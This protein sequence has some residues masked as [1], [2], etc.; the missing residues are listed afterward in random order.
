[1]T[2]DELL[3]RLEETPP[4]EWTPEE[5]ELLRAR[6]LANP[7]VRTALAEQILLEQVLT[8]GLTQ[9]RVTAEQV[10]AR[11]DE[12][13]RA[14]RFLGSWLRGA[15]VL[16]LVAGIGGIWYLRSLKPVD[17]R[18]VVERPPEPTVELPPTVK[19]KPRPTTPVAAATPQPS[20]TVRPPEPTPPPTTAAAADV[21]EPWT[22]MLA[23]AARSFDDFCFTDR[24]LTRDAAGLQRWWTTIN[25]QQR[26][27]GSDDRY[28][29]HLGGTFQLRSPW[30][31]DAA[32]TFW[33]I[34]QQ[35]EVVKIHIW[36]GLHGVTLERRHRP[37]EQWTAFVV[38]K[39]PNE[40]LPATW[41]Y[42]TA[43]NDRA[44]RTGE[45]PFDLRYHNGRIYLSRGD[46]LLLAV[47]LPNPPDGANLEGAVVL[48]AFGLTRVADVP[49]RWNEEED[50][51]PSF[52]E[53]PQPITWP[54]L[55]RAKWTKELP[56]G[57]NF[58]QLGDEGALLTALDTTKPTYATI[59]LPKDGLYDLVYE[60]ESADDQTGIFLGTAEA[61][62]RF[63]VGFYENKPGENLV[64][65]VG[66]PTEL[67]P[68][69]RYNPQAG[70]LTSIAFPA[71]LR[72][73]CGAGLV[74]VYASAD[75]RSWGRILDPFRATDDNPATIGVYCNPGK[76][77]RQIKLTRVR[78]SNYLKADDDLVAQTPVVRDQ[79]DYTSWLVNVL[80]RD[81]DGLHR[82][83]AALLTKGTRYDVAKTLL[84][85]LN[86][87]PSVP[88][89]EDVPAG[90][91]PARP[92]DSTFG[93][94]TLAW[95]SDVAEGNAG[96]EWQGR[97]LQSIADYRPPIADETFDRF[98][99]ARRRWMESPLTTSGKMPVIPT[100]M[101]RDEVAALL[102]AGKW[103][104]LD[105]LCRVLHFF[106][107]KA[108]AVDRRSPPREQIMTLVDWA[109]AQAERRRTVPEGVI[110][111]PTQTVFKPEWRHPL[112]EQ[113]GK[114]GYNVLAE[115]ETALQEKAY[116][117]AC[118]IITGVTAAQA[119]GLLPNAADSDL[120]VSL[121]GAVALAMRD[122]AELR[123]VMQREYGALAQLRLRQATADGDV[124]AVQALTTQFYGTIAAAQAQMWLGDRELAQ[125]DAAR[126]EGCYFATRTE[127][128][129]A[130]RAAID[131]RIRRAAA[132]QGRNC[133][134]A[135]TSAVTLGEWTL[136]PADFERTIE[137]LRK[138]APQ[139]ESRM[140]STVVDAGSQ[141][142]SPI[143][144]P[145]RFTL[146]SFAKV[147]GEFGKNPEQL[148]NRD[149]D[150]IGRQ[151]ASVY[152]EEK[153]TPGKIIVTNRFQVT[154]Y[155]LAD[156]KQLWRTG[157]GAEQ[158][159]AY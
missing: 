115:L 73:V 2:D 41:S 98:T 91:G 121:P 72:M 104:D 56:A 127:L 129:P 111:T 119:V 40:P 146:K 107:G 113:F 96:A 125:G 150:Y 79:G 26:P 52:V 137:E 109:A 83:A 59:P 138:Q 21:D 135:P 46:I 31:A 54:P 93:F 85:G 23:E 148:P 8:R 49:K 152:L 6:A 141:G 108:E 132:M 139:T 74:K 134:G 155:A 57:A 156:G 126:A 18:P 61:Q 158:G 42:A 62:P 44:R 87:T 84:A 112:I 133:G 105:Q 114:E 106:G 102:R 124:D 154:A 143:P 35:T 3:H 131:A 9:V 157:L 39:R 86:S 94:E 37:V 100:Q 45:G 17:D 20:A 80:S 128:P 159:R 64:V 36:S 11:Y 55:A 101:I 25:G 118:R 88:L 103:N 144:P 34:E 130:D 89:L 78:A 142:T 117:D 50:R 116:S 48:K 47:P 122:H 97:F 27:V 123:T 140:S 24:K 145:S 16:L 14:P 30:P 38:T 60:I 28:G 120:L 7:E 29:L 66:R 51:F 69:F 71:R 12:R 5:L 22:P 10:L 151:L 68:R 149:L 81:R 136:S 4:D 67:K 70:P 33:P 92:S 90:K 75:G 13:R 53:Y 63:S 153:G 147:D 82:S 76:G 65:A 1:M 110:P 32:L 19:P 58:E 15:A 43:D 77:K 95:A 99:F